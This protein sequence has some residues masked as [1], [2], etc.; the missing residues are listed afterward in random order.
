MKL[1]KLILLLIII[2]LA[3][4]ATA[5]VIVYD[6]IYVYDTVWIERVEMEIYS[7]VKEDYNKKNDIK[8]ATFI[9]DSVLHIDTSI[10]LFDMK[11]GT[12]L[13]ILILATIQKIAFTQTKPPFYS[14]TIL[15]F[16]YDMDY[17]Q[18]GKN[19]SP[20]TYSSYTSLDFGLGLGFGLH[21]NHQFKRH[22]WLESGLVG[23]FHT[24]L[25][26]FEINSN[27]IDDRISEEERF[28]FLDYKASLFRL[29]APINIHYEFFKSKEDRVF[30][31]VFGGVSLST[32]IGNANKSTTDDYGYDS[33]KL[34]ATTTYKSSLI[35]VYPELGLAV[36]IA[37]MMPDCMRYYYP[38]TANMRK[39]LKLSYSYPLNPRR[40]EYSYS[41]ITNGVNSYTENNKVFNT[42]KFSGGIINLNII[43]LF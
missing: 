18:P 30:L 23:S 8:T 27:N 17:L 32:N 29:K 22:W 38:K 14:K 3:S 26:N 5:Q 4:S 42:Y 9:K 41:L 28:I 24:I 31:S 13:K 36:N 37:N 19:S 33:V 2:S 35:T 1:I 11:K 20:Y 25:P 12:F 34:V 7:D 43:M 16:S 10:N 6:T 15:G 21:V 39:I 40:V